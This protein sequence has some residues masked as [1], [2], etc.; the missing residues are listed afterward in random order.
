MAS[1]LG[2]IVKDLVQDIS[3]TDWAKDRRETERKY[4]AGEIEEREP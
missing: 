2:S 1:T 3:E 4:Q